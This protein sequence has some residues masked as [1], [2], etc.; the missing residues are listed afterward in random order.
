MSQLGIE[1]DEATVEGFDVE[2]VEGDAVL[3]VADL[4]NR[5]WIRRDRTVYW[6][7]LLDR[8]SVNHARLHHLHSK[9]RT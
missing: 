7:S 8:K 3:R 5:I 6:G 9:Q 1:G 4:I 2:G